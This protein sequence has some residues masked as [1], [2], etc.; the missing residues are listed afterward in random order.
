MLLGT[1]DDFLK[2]FTSTLRLKIS[3]K[4]ITPNQILPKIKAPKPI[5]QKQKS[6]NS[7]FPENLF[8]KRTYF[9]E[10]HLP[11]HSV[12]RKLIFE[13]IKYC[14]LGFLTTFF[15]ATGIYDKWVFWQKGFL[16][17]LIRCS[18]FRPNENSGFR[19]QFWFDLWISGN[20]GWAS[21]PSIF[22]LNFFN[23]SVI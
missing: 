11:E 7:H 23:S 17:N 12:P 16:E 2:Y 5:G 18:G 3:L 4:F 21:F 1:L 8:A 19:W 14:I 6:S 10:N 13:K 15:L 20:W 9:P 22:S